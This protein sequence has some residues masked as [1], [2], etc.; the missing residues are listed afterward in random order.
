MDQSL[1]I[2]VLVIIVCASGISSLIFLK[3]DVS[4]TLEGKYNIQLN[5]ILY[6]F[7]MICFVVFY[8]G[9]SFVLYL[10]Y[11]FVTSLIS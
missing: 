7:V 2:L 3:V 10:L 6:L 1:A 11:K 9:A 8:S 4:D 5:F